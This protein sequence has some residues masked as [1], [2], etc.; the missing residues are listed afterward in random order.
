MPRCCTRPVSGNR[1]RGLAAMARWSSRRAFMSGGSQ[2]GRSR[3]SLLRKNSTSP[4]AASAPRL[5]PGPKLR[6]ASLRRWRKRSPKSAAPRVG[7]SQGVASVEPLST[8]MTSKKPPGVCSRRLSRQARVRSQ[9]LSTGMTMDR[10]GRFMGAGTVL[11]ADCWGTPGR[12]GAAWVRLPIPAAG[13]SRGW[14][15]MPC[16]A[17]GLGPPRP[18]TIDAA[19][20]RRIEVRA[21]EGGA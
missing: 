6:L 20:P 19:R 4:R 9:W 17:N 10:W 12:R 21:G 15:G 16:V 5:Q 1:H 7:H 14:R 3:V 8:T 18:R 11:V 2:S 13:T